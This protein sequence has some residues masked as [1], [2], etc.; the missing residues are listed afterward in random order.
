MPD[1]LVQAITLEL[2]GIYLL[3]LTDGLNLLRRCHKQESILRKYNF[4]G[5][6]RKSHGHFSSHALKPGA[7]PEILKGRCTKF[8]GP[9]LPL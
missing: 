3:N 7:D 9:E 4:I 2:Y 8:S 5:Y 1:I 6:E